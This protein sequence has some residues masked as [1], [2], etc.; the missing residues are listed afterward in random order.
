MQREVY[1]LISVSNL[2]DAD[3][4]DLTYSKVMRLYKMGKLHWY[5]EM[6]EEGAARLQVPSD[7]L[8]VKVSSSY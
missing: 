5:S 3:L 6:T 8:L 4:K 7:C 1:L 2:T